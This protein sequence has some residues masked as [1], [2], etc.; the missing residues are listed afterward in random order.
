MADVFLSARVGKS[1]SFEHKVSL[2][3]GSLGTQGR[4]LCVKLPI[5][6]LSASLLQIDQLSRVNKP[7]LGTYTDC[8]EGH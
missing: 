2:H 6:L 8:M 3:G 4:T 7:S 5:L 1:R